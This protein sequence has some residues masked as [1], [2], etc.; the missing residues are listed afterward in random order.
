MAA[1]LLI[2]MVVALLGGLI[3]VMGSPSPYEE[4]TEKEFEEEA[5]EKSLLGAAMIGLDKALQPNRT[6]HVLVQKKRV[7]KD[8]ALPGEPPPEDEKTERD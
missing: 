1:F 4:M 7:E 2:A 6:E 8:G 5:K 3:Y